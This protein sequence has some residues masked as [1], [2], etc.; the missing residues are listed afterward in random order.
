[1]NALLIGS[2]FYLMLPMPALLHR[3]GFCVHVL[4]TSSPMAWVK[5]VNAL[6]VAA[7]PDDLL[8]IACRQAEHDFELIVVTDDATLNL[9]KN[10]DLA[11]E[12]KLKLL[13]VLRAENF[14]HISSKIGLSRCLKI[15]GINTP[16]FAVAHCPDELKV[17]ASKI[18][19]PLMVKIDYSGGGEGVYE[20]TD[21]S[22]IDRLQS[23]ALAFPLL[24]QRK[25]PGMLLDACAFFRNG[26]LV[27]FNYDEAMDFMNGPFSPTKVRRF[28]STDQMDKGI[29]AEL[30]RLGRALGAHGFVN[31]T[32]IHSAIDQERYYIEADMRPNVWVEYPKFFGE[33]PAEKIRL[34]FAQ[35][36]Y[37]AHPKKAS[38]ISEAGVV[39]AYLPRMTT[40]E[41]VMNKYGC[42]Q[43]FD[44]YAGYPLYKF[45]FKYRLQLLGVK[46]IKPCLPTVCWVYLKRLWWGF[47]R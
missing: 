42:I 24:L 14:E 12:V 27:F 28:F 44:N 11:D 2:A 9:I 7:N 29:C 3:A 1:M 37:F 34:Y 19:F 4:T 38:N 31:I 17:Q 16:D 20:C 5:Y 15:A 6:T 40:L 18:G 45:L 8:A 43:S 46:F 23:Q 26:R 30:E 22:Q 10:A 21:S 25:I 36:R 41:I 39:L 32:C 33:D 47:F 13:P 35:G